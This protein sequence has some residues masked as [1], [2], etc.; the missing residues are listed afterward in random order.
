MPSDT[1]ELSSDLAQRRERGELTPLE[2]LLLWQRTRTAS[3]SPELLRR[4]AALAQALEELHARGGGAAAALRVLH[5]HTALGGELAGADQQALVGV[6]SQDWTDVAAAAAVEAAGLSL[7]ALGERGKLGGI[8]EALARW[9][10]LR[11]PAASARE[12]LALFARCEGAEPWWREAVQRG[13]AQASEARSASWAQAVWRWWGEEPHRAQEILRLV[14]RG[15]ANERWL[16]EHVPCEVA[17]QELS[18]LIEECRERRWSQLAARLLCAHRDLSPRIEAL[19]RFGRSCPSRAVEVVLEGFEPREVIAEAQHNPWQPLIWAAARRTRRDPALFSA[20]TKGAAWLAAAHERGEGAESV[21]EYLPKEVQARRDY[22][23]GYED[24]EQALRL[25]VL[26]LGASPKGAPLVD[27]G[28]EARRIEQRVRAAKLRDLVKVEYGLAAQPGDLQALLQ[29][30]EPH[31]VHFAGHAGE[32]VLLLEADGGGKAPVSGRAFANLMRICS[33]HVQVV[34]LNGCSTSE[35]AKEIARYVDFAIG[36]NGE[37][38]QTPAHEFAAAFYGALASGK[39][40]RESFEL[41]KNQLDLLGLVN[42]VELPE[43]YAEQ[44]ADEGFLFC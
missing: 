29:E 1:S 31:I 28:A 27:Y 8:E 26:L 5:A 44:G 4:V 30:H 35:Q 7:A 12:A 3:E 14:E 25:K 9:V 17:A 34:V 37:T 18:S 23:D 32:R 40:L 24:A 43:L 6:L 19:R 42:A 41:G 2:A 36:M 11:L 21:E 33:D 39:P 15:A 10:E 22:R 16:L 13:V 38:T 20:V